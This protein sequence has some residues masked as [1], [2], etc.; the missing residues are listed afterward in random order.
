MKQAFG[1]Q[2]KKRA[3]EPRAIALGSL[4]NKHPP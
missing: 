3:N 4:A 1:L 2:M